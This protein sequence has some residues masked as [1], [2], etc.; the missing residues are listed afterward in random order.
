MRY[1]INLILTEQHYGL[2]I[3]SAWFG[4][5]A[6]GFALYALFLGFCWSDVIGGALFWWACHR[7]Y[8]QPSDDWDEETA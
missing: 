3:A 1:I 2:L 8:Q 4:W 5:F 7:W 6:A